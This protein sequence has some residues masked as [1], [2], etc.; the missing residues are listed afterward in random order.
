M[1]DEHFRLAPKPL[2]ID[3]DE[4]TRYNQLMCTIELSCPVD[5]DLTTFLKQ[6]AWPCPLLVLI[7]Y[8]IF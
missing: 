1:R 5:W 3:G 2:Y 8:S 4:R 7:I 6:S